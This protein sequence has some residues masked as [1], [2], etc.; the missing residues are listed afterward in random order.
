[1][2]KDHPPTPFCQKNQGGPTTLPP[3]VLFGKQISIMAENGQKIVLDCEKVLK[4]AQNC[5]NQL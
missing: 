1:L 4:V 3:I 2:R 5:P